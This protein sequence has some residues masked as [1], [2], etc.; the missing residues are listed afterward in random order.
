MSVN[1]Q[2][3]QGIPYLDEAAV[4][5]VL[6]YEDL[7]PAMERA[8]AE[9]STGKVLQ[10]VRSILPVK[11]HQ[12]FFGVMPAVY[13]DIMGAKLVTLFPNNAGTSLPT[14]Q[15]VIV[16]LRATTGEPL[17]VMDGR[18]ITEM[19][20]AAVTAVA[21]KHLSKPDS[22]VLAILGSGVQARAHYAALQCVRKFDEVRVW[23]RNPDHARAV[24]HEIGAK[25]MA[26]D[27]AV[28][29]ADVVVT[30][31]HA[32]E[33]VL[34]GRWLNPGALVAAVGAVGQSNREVDDAVM[35][36]AVIVDSRDAAA[37]EAGE[38]LMSGAKIYAEL[39][40]ILAGGKPKPEA[41]R[42]VFKSLGLAV[43]DLAAGSLMI[44]ALGR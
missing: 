5:R 23:S 6:R 21:V 44:N 7:I 2:S 33:P 11:E 4:R 38:I 1:P 34:F 25:A 22:K 15:G 26:A 14:H 41:K 29:E 9:F 36:G 28:R 18:L 39:G 30:V 32:S 3:Q 37:V 40:E 43:E 13:G 12:G 17:A 8:L 16:L 19:R 42:V 31:T 24:A 27:A 35:Q 10:P 20:T